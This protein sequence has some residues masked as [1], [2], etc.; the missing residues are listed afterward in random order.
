[1]HEIV[2]IHTCIYKKG[3]T[4]TLEEQDF[5]FWAYSFFKYK[6]K[7]QKENN[8]LYI[9]FYYVIYQITYKLSLRVYLHSPKPS[10]HDN[11]RYHKNH[12]YEIIIT[13]CKTTESALNCY[14]TCNKLRLFQIKIWTASEKRAVL[15]SEFQLSALILWLANTYILALAHSVVVTICNWNLSQ[16]VFGS[17]HV[18]WRKPGHDTSQNLIRIC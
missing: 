15:H 8:F 18:K 6:S 2:N 10:H 14:N 7:S 12:I 1:M 4:S 13:C 5:L 3:N 16:V 17:F 9:F 11:S